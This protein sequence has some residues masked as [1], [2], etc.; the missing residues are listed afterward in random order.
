VAKAL[1]SEPLQIRAA[2]V[3]DHEDWARLRALLWPDADAAELLDELPGLVTG[4]NALRAWLLIDGHGDPVGFIELSMR[5]ML[6]GTP[7]DPFP[8]LEGLWIAPD[9]RRTGAARDLL[10]SVETWARDAGHTELGS[11]AS[12]DNGESHE[13]HAACGFEEV[14]RIV[15]YYKTL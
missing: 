6:D 4:P 8:Y 2:T 1:P 12:L 11:D 9:H 7:R 10:K 14:E 13:W 3:P 5:N 15:L